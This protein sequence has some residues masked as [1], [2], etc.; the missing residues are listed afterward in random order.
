MA[1]SILDGKRILAVDDEPD[2]L[3]VLSEEILS[4]C[5]C[6]IDTATS[7]EQGAD[8]I[9]HNLYDMVILD[10]MG[11][12]GFDLLRLAVDRDM[13]AVMLTAKELTPEAL[14]K[15][16]DQGARAFLPKDKLGEIVPFLE[17]VLAHEHKTVWQR[18]LK[19]MEDYWDE[20][21]SDEWRR[22]FPHYGY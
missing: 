5:S 6:T 9:E 13:R 15:S 16:H 8:M 22:R 10:I 3:T 12:R 11:V 18:I 17:D 20:K 19:K 7:Y 4:S 1:E 14:H 2:V 21:F